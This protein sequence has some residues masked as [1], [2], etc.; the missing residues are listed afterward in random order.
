MI[1]IGHMILQKLF[2]PFLKLYCHNFPIS[3]R[4]RKDKQLIDELSQERDKIIDE[5]LS[6]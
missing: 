1:D 5:I 3:G 2:N 6:R 4:A